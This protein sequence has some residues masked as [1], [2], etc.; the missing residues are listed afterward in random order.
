MRIL[1]ITS[2]LNVGGVTSS[3]LSL[4]QGLAQRGHRVTIASGGGSLEAPVEAIGLGHWRVP[5]HTSQ[6]CSPQVFAATRTLAGRLKQEPVDVLHGHTRVGQV[7]ACRLSRR[8]SVPYVATW[9]G[10]FRPHIG[11]RLWP[12]TGD[13]TIA[14]SEPVREHLIQTFRVPP[15][16]AHLIPHGIDPSPF[17]APIR[18]SEQERLRQALGLG[19]AGPVVGTVAR[20]V[21]SKGVDHLVRSFTQVR[22]ALPS[23]QLVIVGNGEERAR[24]EQLARDQGI[25]DAVHFTG[26]LPD[27]RVALSLMDTF[28]FLPADREGFGLSLLEAMASARPIVAVRQGGGATWVLEQSGVGTLVEPGDAT[29][30]AFAVTR[31]L[32]DRKAARREGER[33]RAVVRERYALS[34]MVADVEDVYEQ[35]LKETRG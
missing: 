21:A 3:I 10:F 5:L 6:E 8:L 30:L 26:T 27:T 35:I 13:A 32:R 34:R 9:H 20:L 2:H 25:A 29:A 12:C 23:A 4:S 22:A 15:Q 14:V 7:V 24:L 31:L 1:H 18:P 16:R 33:A 19:H 28:V 11:R 17:E